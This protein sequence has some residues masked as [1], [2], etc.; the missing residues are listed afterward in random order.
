MATGPKNERIITI[1]SP[2]QIKDK[3]DNDK[4]VLNPTTLV[5]KYE[6]RPRELA[7]F[8]YADFASIL[9]QSRGYKPK[10]NDMETED[11]EFT[12]ENNEYE[13]TDI[14]NMTTFGPDKSKFQK[15]Y[16]K[17]QHRHVIRWVGYN[18]EKYPNN[19]Y[20]EQL[21]IYIPWHNEDQ[22][23]PPGKDFRQEFLDNIKEIRLKIAT[24]KKEAIDWNETFKEVTQHLHG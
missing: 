1:Q 14:F 2:E 4:D 21:M 6:T 3:D 23:F 10:T 22:T 20:R 13:Y 18:E 5:S 17:R 24:Y 9:D 8:C 19:F 15:V 11:D 7:H 12:T 16:H